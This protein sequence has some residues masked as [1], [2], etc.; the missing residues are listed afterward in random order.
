MSYFE[1]C[2]SQPCM[3][4]KY[5]KYDSWHDDSWCTHKPSPEG[6]NDR[7][8]VDKWGSCEYFEEDK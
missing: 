3:Y 5:K 7:L 1:P 8:Q 4:C 2:Q 6:L